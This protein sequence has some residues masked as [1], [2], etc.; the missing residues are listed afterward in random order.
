MNEPIISPWIF[1][2]IDVFDNVTFFVGIFVS[3]MIIFGCAGFIIGMAEDNW[4]KF[5]PNK[6]IMICFVISLFILTFVPSRTTVYKMFIASYITPQNIEYVGDSI[7][8]LLDNI[9]NRVA[10]Y[11]EK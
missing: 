1:Y 4:K 10:K 2:W 11:K 3:V 7:D 9:E 8:S 5:M 6:C